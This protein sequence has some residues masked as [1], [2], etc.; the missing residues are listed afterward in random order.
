MKRTI[1]LRESEL[2]RM[3]SESVRKVINE[4]SQPSHE[5]F[6]NGL[7]F[8]IKNG[9]VKCEIQKKREDGF[10]SIKFTWDAA[11][12]IGLM[13]AYI[14][15]FN[16]WEYK[17]HGFEIKWKVRD[18]VDSISF[19]TERNLQPY[20]DYVFTE[21]IKATDDFKPTRDLLTKMLMPH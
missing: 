5:E 4:V 21:A 10:I 14:E 8:Y 1:R 16:E 20:A 11:N 13:W 2:R 9:D 6:L 18:Y 7:Q 19:E 3:I 12:L 17:A 15:P